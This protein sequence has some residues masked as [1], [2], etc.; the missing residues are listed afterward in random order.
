MNDLQ[1][2]VIDNAC[3]HGLPVLRTA[4]QG[5]RTG[6]DSLPAELLL[7]IFREYMSD[8]HELKYGGPKPGA[9][10]LD[11]CLRW[12]ELVRQDPACW[13]TVRVYMDLDVE[14]LPERST[15]RLKEQARHADRI[16]SRLKE[17]FTYTAGRKVDLT[18]S[19]S[20]RYG[21]YATEDFLI[22]HM[23]PLKSYYENAEFINDCFLSIRA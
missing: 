11:T 10:L 7:I 15:E 14:E 22:D 8:V 3:L 20:A 17:H 23:P 13:T 4:A 1:M 6:I 2:T 5:A 16:L 12:R 9:A 21:L 18:L 19:Y